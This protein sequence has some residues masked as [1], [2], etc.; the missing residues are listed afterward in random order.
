MTGEAPPGAES[1]KGKK[2]KATAPKAK[3]AAPKAAK[4]AAPKAKSAPVVSATKKEHPQVA[5][6]EVKL[7]A[8]PAAAVAAVPAAAAA[9][10]VTCK[11][12]KNCPAWCSRA[13]EVAAAMS[14]HSL[15]VAE[16]S[17]ADGSIVLTINGEP[18]RGCE[19]IV[20]YL[21]DVGGVS[22]ALTPG[23]QH[24]LSWRRSA[25][26]AAASKNL[27]ASVS[28]AS[29]L[30]GSACTSADIIVAAWA[31][32]DPSGGTL[33]PKVQTWIKSVIGDAPVATTTKSSGGGVVSG[34]AAAGKG[35]KKAASTAPKVKSTHG[36]W[37][38]TV[39]Y[40]GFIK[41]E[42]TEGSMHF[43]TS[44]REKEEQLELL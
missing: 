27:E 12:S 14:G 31:A 18:L 2:E 41:V 23:V 3:A 39:T 42:D 33:P 7:S 15:V 20:G 6:T 28:S 16:S 24:W 9:G 11:A 26:V 40:I 21:L 32:G 5:A 25:D 43:F 22:V 37:G 44:P 1:K 34:G 4:A 30:T 35:A 29:F 13:V 19:A 8:A 17:D 36:T 38:S 10:G